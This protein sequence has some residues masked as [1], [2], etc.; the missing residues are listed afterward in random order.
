MPNTQPKYGGTRSKIAGVG[1]HRVVLF[2]TD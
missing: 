2:I 1:S